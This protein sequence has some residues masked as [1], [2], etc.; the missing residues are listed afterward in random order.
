MKKFLT[1]ILF[2]ITLLAVGQVPQGFSYQGIAY[3][4]IGAPVTNPISLRISILDN[5]AIGTAVYAETFSGIQTT[6]QGVFSLNIGLGTPVSPFNSSTF[7]AIDWGVNTKFI[8]VEIDVTGGISYLLVG[9]NQLMSV[10][11]ALYAKNTNNEIEMINSISDLRNVPVN[12]PRDAN[13]VI[14]LKGYYTEGDGGEGFFIFK[15][16]QTIS[17]KGGIF[18]K[19]NSITAT[20]STDKGRWVRQYSGSI[21]AIYFGIV[22]YPLYYPPTGQTN[23]ERIN[24]AIEYV[25]EYNLGYIHGNPQNIL[26]T[27]MPQDMTLYFP[28]G[29]YEID[30]S[31]KLYPEINI[32]GD[33]ATTFWPN[34]LVGGENKY[35]F[36]ITNGL[37]NKINLENLQIDFSY[38]S[39]GLGG[40]HLKAVD[41]SGT[42]G[43][44]LYNSNFRNITM[45]SPTGHGIYLE[46]GVLESGREANQYLHFE[47][48]FIERSY[49][50]N[51]CL[52][53]TG[54]AFNNFFIGCYF[55]T[56]FATLSGGVEI[57]DPGTNVFISTKINIPQSKSSQISFINC[58][59]GG[60][61]N[62]GVSYGFKI[63]KSN[64]ITLENCWFEDTEFAISLKDSNT[65]NIQNCY[66]ANA[67]GLGSL[68]GSSINNK[69]AC[70]AVENTEATIE[71]NYSVVTEPN[72]PNIQN[73]LFIA[74]YGE[75]N[76]I[77]ARNNTFGDIRLSE[78]YG[79]TQ[80]T[81]ISNINTYQS[82]PSQKQGIETNGKKLVLVRAGL[83]N[84][85]YRINSTIS[86]GETI[87]I[88]AEEKDINF[89][90]WNSQSETQGRN[91][92]LNGK[93]SLKLLQGQGALF[94]KLDGV[95]GNEKCSYQLVSIAN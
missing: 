60:T 62:K 54:A 34:S 50:F 45:F 46:G 63:E 61:P 37:L 36:E 17:D 32:K 67:A 86:A 64:N 15:E 83:N 26:N 1:I 78:T 21:N 20:P 38:S 71:R 48:I 29:S 93:S 81:T 30:K 58:A 53:I 89:L 72:S 27:V 88:R 65:I 12:L 11:Y 7:S 51:N 35:L 39:K 74:G 80:Y 70:I 92:Y 28:S 14:Y 3:N 68:E 82:S 44:G 19:P 90:A 49:G 56:P 57:S 43:G 25:H 33:V 40:I 13:K 2:L 31:I 84:E 42:A 73:E 91:I 23:G 75:N 22:K 69:G 41:L 4:N 18:I 52:K 66:F 76:V 5:S 47:D 55:Q 10:P 16:N 6:P 87:F 95:N 9:T 8:K 24:N 79:I 94:I 59:S 77:N 85:I